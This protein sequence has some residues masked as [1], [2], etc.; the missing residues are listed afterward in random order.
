[1]SACLSMGLIVAATLSGIADGEVELVTE[2][3]KF[4]EGPVYLPDGTLLF[5]DIPANRIYNGEGEVVYEPT[6]NANGLTLDL[7][8][9]LLRAEHSGRRVAR[10][11][12]DGEFE[13]IVDSYEGNKL[14]SPNDLCV[15][16][17]ATIFFTD[18]PYGG[19][20]PEMEI[21]G[22]YAISPE[23]ELKRLVD[24]FVK[25]NGIALS[26]DE[27]ILYVADTDESKLRAFDVAEDGTLSNDRLLHEPPRPDGIK[28]DVEGN[29]YITCQDGIRVVAPD[30]E[31]IETIEFPQQPSN[32]CFGGP[33]DKTLFAAA[34]TGVYKVKVTI[35]G[36]RPTPK[37]MAGSGSK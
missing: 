16:S 36:I 8:G 14:H 25:P 26:P 17:D 27:K 24:D 11:N 7:E 10:L 23:G 34:R 20:D 31:L 2:G 32:C 29:I 12:A 1:M 22:V 5:T 18:P 9:R 19:N 3:Y 37:E 35:E 6:G 21:F 28:V 15:R 33:D 30:G 13:T 4:T